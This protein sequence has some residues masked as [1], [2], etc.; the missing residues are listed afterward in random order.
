[1]S[2]TLRAAR[3]ACAAAVLAACG[4]APA[5]PG[6]T[7][8]VDDGR[9]RLPTGA[10]LDPAGSSVDAGNLPL[11]MA[12]SPDHRYAVLLLNGWKERAVQ[13]I[14]RRSGSVTQTIPLPSA[15]LGL[16]FSPDGG[17]IAASGGN[18]DAVYLLSWRDGV[19]R[20]ADSIVLDAKRGPSGTRYPAGLAWSSDGQYLYVAENL[21]DSLAVLDVSRKQVMQRFA[22]Q[23]YPYGVV[24]APDGTVYVSAWG[25]N[26]VSVFSNT[27]GGAL[28]RRGVVRAG[29]HPSAM[30]LSADG[31][32]L[33]VASASTDRVAIVD[34]K[35]LAVVATLHDT[36]PAGPGE[37]ST[38]NALALSADGTRL[39]VAEADNNAVAVFDLAVGGGTLIGRVPVGWY[40]AALSALGD[41]LLVLNAKG[42]GSRPNPGDPTPTSPSGAAPHEY[43]LGQLSGT[44]TTVLGAGGDAASLA[45]LT[46]RVA[47][48][49]GWDDPARGAAHYPPFEHVIYIIKENRTFDEVLS[50]LPNVDGDTSLLFFGASSAPNHHALARRFGAYD[51]FFVNA[52]VSADG[53]IWSDAA[54]APDYVEKTVSLQYADQGRTYDYEGQNRDKEPD[55]D[56]NEPANGYLWNAASRA[57][58]TYRDYGEFTYWN[59]AS[60]GAFL[61]T[62]KILK[63][64]VNPDYPGYNLSITDQHRMDIFLE[65]FHQFERGGNLPAL[66]TMTL[67]NDHTSGMRAGAISPRAAFAD[68]DLALGRL[69]EALSRSAYWKNTVVFVV[70]DDAQNGP[71]HVDSHRSVM[72]AISAYSRSGVRHR[73]TNTTD[74]VATIVEILKLGSLSQFDFYGRPLRDAFTASPDLAPY[75]ALVPAFPLD[76]RNPPA[77]GGTASRSARALD[78]SA[79]DRADEDDFNRELWRA[80]KGETVPYPGIHRMPLLEAAAER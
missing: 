36:P 45:P 47:R 14:D 59:D 24:V 4:G 3:I 30:V 61:G 48:A 67:P 53:H 9:G 49:N 35:A 71:D 78:L 50:D 57:G 55:D 20:L 40:P 68:N 79:A 29:R 72:Y 18:A 73:F 64:H 34:T 39:F 25:G 46:A 19:A 77:K 28:E 27:G 10:R 7:A 16:A 1:V 70:E 31:A 37:G 44:I 80:L 11:A 32:R 26:T 23:P 52:E 8:A 43:T 13:V 76:D 63:G 75:T 15:F 56:V 2:S 21:G 17:T 33:F 69:V 51:R 6:V 22:T 41:T 74:V 66:I 42:R 5:S 60:A 38:P 12:L 62:K 65:E 58:I 54:Y